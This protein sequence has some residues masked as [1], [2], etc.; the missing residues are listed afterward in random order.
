MS[1]Q[2]EAL[3]KN[4][5]EWHGSFTQISPQGEVFGDIPS[6]VSLTPSEDR[7]T[8]RQV[9]TK[10]PDEQPSEL[11]LEYKSLGKGVLF[12]EDGAFSQGSIQ[13]APYTQFGAEFGLIHGDCRMRLVEL[14]NQ[15]SQLDSLTLIRE[16]LAGSETPAR[17]QLSLEQL[18]GR[19]QGVATTIYPDWQPSDTY[20]SHLQLSLANPDLLVQELSFGDRTIK[21]T[22]IISDQQITFTQGESVVQVLMLPEGASATCPLTIIPRQPFF[23][24]VG[25]LINFNLRQRLIRSYDAKGEWVSLT[26]VVEQKLS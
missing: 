14:Y 19:W 15:Q 1:S 9:V 23:I 4:T 25:W 2:W 16:R 18:L 22:G 11:V 10:Y 20:T 7:Q 5:G 6:I 26:L 3:L 12:H 8:M 13:W 21:S 24:E 17:P